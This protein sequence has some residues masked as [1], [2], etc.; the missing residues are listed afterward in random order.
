MKQLIDI[1][2]YYLDNL[3]GTSFVFDTSVGRIV[4]KFSEAS[5]AHLIGL[6]HFD[7]SYKGQNAWDGIIKGD[8]T[9]NKLKRKDKNIYK[10]TL[11]PR[12]FVLENVH[13]IFAKSKSIKK[14]IKKS[15]SSDGFDCDFIFYNAEERYYDI[16]T[17]FIDKSTGS[18]CSAASLLRFYDGDFN[19]LKYIKPENPLIEINQYHTT[20]EIVYNDIDFDR[21]NALTQ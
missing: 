14:Y 5:F 11:L 7:K 9:L 1:Q 20:T 17:C 3:C 13:E 4:V 8:I 16:V 15:S 18:Y 6:H 19:V 10:N 21:L 2:K 12:T